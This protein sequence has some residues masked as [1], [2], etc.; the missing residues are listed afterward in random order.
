MTHGNLL[1]RDHNIQTLLPLTAH[2]DESTQIYKPVS[3]IPIFCALWK[4]N[5]KKPEKILSKG[6]FEQAACVCSVYQ[7]NF[8][9]SSFLSK[10][11]LLPQLVL[12]LYTDLRVSSCASCVYANI[13]HADASHF[14]PSVWFT[15][16]CYLY[17]NYRPVS[18]HFLIKFILFLLWL[19]TN[20]LFEIINSSKFINI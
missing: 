2:W 13:V 11:I 10:S 19:D 16:K 3:D 17:Q 7:H 18:D 6:Q 15:P 9:S 12:T 1:K 5:E 4:I 20:L 14:D 8:F